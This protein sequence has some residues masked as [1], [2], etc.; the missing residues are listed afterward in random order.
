MVEKISVV[1]GDLGKSA[2]MPSITLSIPMPPGA[3]QPA[4]APAASPAPPSAA[5]S[6]EAQ[7]GK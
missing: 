6:R 2:I 1:F 3:A 5:P 7:Q 4:S